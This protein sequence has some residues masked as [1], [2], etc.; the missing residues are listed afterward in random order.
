MSAQKAKVVKRG[1]AE[2]P[3]EKA[4]ERGKA[5]VEGFF[6]AFSGPVGKLPKPV[7][8]YG[9]WHEEAMERISRAIERRFKRINEFF[10]KLDE[11]ME[12]Y[13]W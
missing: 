9:E 3:R 12:E 13:L 4:K 1:V 5:Y 8:E 10:R 7:R 6:F 2:R 11:L